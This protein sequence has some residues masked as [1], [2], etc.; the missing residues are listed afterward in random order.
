MG[1]LRFVRTPSLEICLALTVWF[2]WYMIGCIEVDLA[3]S[4]QVLLLRTLN[5]RWQFQWPILP[6]VLGLTGVF[7]A[8]CRMGGGAGK[9]IERRVWQMTVLCAGVAALKLFSLWDLPTQVFPFIAVLWSPHATWTLACTWLLYLHLPTN[10]SERC[11]G[12]R[13]LNRFRAAGIAF[14]VALLIYGAYTVYFCQ[15]TLLHGDEGQYL[16]VTQS[17]LRDGDMDLSNNLDDDHVGEFHDVRFDVHKATGSPPGKLYS[18]HPI[19]LSVALVPFYHLGLSLWE[20][21]RLACALA[22]AVVAAGTVGV[23]LFWL[24]RLGICPWAAWLA[25]AIMAGSPPLFLFCNQLFPDVPALLISLVVL[26]ATASWQIPGG[27]FV[28]WGRLEPLCIGVLSALLFVLP[29]LHARFTP[30]ALAAGSL[31]LLQAWFSPRRAINLGVLGIVGLFGFTGIISFNFAFSG[32]WM[33]PFRPG[34]AWEEGALDPTTWSISIPGHWFHVRK[35]IV[36]SAPIFLLSVIGLAL[37]ARARDRRILLAA[38]IYLVSAI[39]NGLHADW[40]FGYCYPARFLLTAL[41]ALI[42]CLAIALEHFRLRAFGLFVTFFAVTIGVDGLIDTIVIPEMGYDGNNL[43]NREINLHYPWHA[44]FFSVSKTWSHWVDLAYWILLIIGATY[45]ALSNPGTRYLRRGACVAV[46][47]LAL[48]LWGR[49]DALGARLKVA[50]RYDL[51]NFGF[52]QDDKSLPSMVRFPLVHRDIIQRTG[53]QVAPSRFAADGTKH[54]AGLLT[55]VSMPAL[56]PGRYRLFFP[57]LV[58]D[59]QADKP[60]GHVLLSRQRTVPA[61]A[62][63]ERRWTRP[64]PER[65]ESD[66]WDMTFSIRRPWIGYTHVLFSG[67]GQLSMGRINLDYYPRMMRPTFE[68]IREYSDL[69][70]RSDEELAVA[71]KYLGLPAG[72]YRVSYELEGSVWES[73]IERDPDAVSMAVFTSTPGDSGSIETQIEPWF[74]QDR[75]LSQSANREELLRPVAES[76]QAPWWICIPMLG[77]EVYELEFETNEISDVWLLV[78]YGGRSKMQVD[79]IRLSRRLQQ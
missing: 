6:W 2:V 16:R 11:D 39:V 64:L 58:V 61:V 35:G 62:A 15:V 9:A 46:L 13:T 23:C 55:S 4:R 31:L 59:G 79:A 76:I 60:P 41:P 51:P 24:L 1:R 70:S 77:A 37:L 36:N 43:F 20:N 50:V 32:D 10:E 63:W 12:V 78:K 67:N 49:M 5:P 7:L 29:F 71:T 26:A 8:Y 33:G 74:G 18:V 28:Y 45:L 22:M 47:C 21:P 73:W 72:A 25:T 65:Q 14:G 57:D 69:V 17:L 68:P 48:L 66:A 53:E 52:G 42:I 40:G 38:G 56:Q 3:A 19:G 75:K 30:I 44:H 34:N 54:G 27:R